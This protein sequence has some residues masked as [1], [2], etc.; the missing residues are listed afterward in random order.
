MNASC[1]YLTF[2]LG[3]HLRVTDLVDPAIKRHD[4]RAH[5]QRTCPRAP[6]DFVHSDDDLGAVPTLTFD[7]ESRGAVA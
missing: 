2:G 5:R 6:S 3:Q 4:D 1:E 7:D